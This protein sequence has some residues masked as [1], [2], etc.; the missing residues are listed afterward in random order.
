MLT[1]QHCMCAT[2]GCAL[3]ETIAM[4]S[5]RTEKMLS[6]FSYGTKNVPR[7]D[8]TDVVLGWN[9]TRNCSGMISSVIFVWDTRVSPAEYSQPSA[10][11][12]TVAALSS[13]FFGV[14]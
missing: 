12:R 2:V 13:L 8:R 1:A 9:S 4:V 14:V 10:G 3:R 7:P 5:L 6:M 11:V